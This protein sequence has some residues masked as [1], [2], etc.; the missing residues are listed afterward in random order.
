MAMKPCRECGNDVSDRAKTCPHCGIE[1]PAYT[2]PFFRAFLVVFFACSVLAIILSS[3]R[4]LSAGSPAGQSALAA[5]WTCWA[6]GMRPPASTRPGVDRVGPRRAQELNSG[7]MS[8]TGMRGYSCDS[9]MCTVM[10]DP[11]VWAQM[12]H[13]T[14]RN[15]VVDFGIG[16]AY[17]RGAQ[18]TDVRDASTH[19]RMGRYSTRNDN[20]TIDI[21]WP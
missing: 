21:R 10:F 15:V 3:R 14:R 4:S 8:T 18:W 17:G 11:G 7:M 1:R 5:L 6:S 16:F 2:R 19:R 20:V 12:E 9:E 13:G